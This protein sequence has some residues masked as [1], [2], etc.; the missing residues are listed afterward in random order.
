MVSLFCICG[1]PGIQQ[2]L[3]VV[4][5]H[6]TVGNPS[7]SPQAVFIPLS[8]HQQGENQI[9]PPD[10]GNRSIFRKDE[11]SRT[12][13]GDSPERQYVMIQFSTDEG[14]RTYAGTSEAVIG[15]TS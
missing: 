8:E 4:G 7:T 12:T 9:R 11:K 14:K 6:L 5:L 1:F 2:T 13:P 10:S 3:S 15:F